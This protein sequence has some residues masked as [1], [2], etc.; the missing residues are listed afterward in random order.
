M[1]GDRNTKFFH[2][3]ANFRRK[4][5][6]IQ[7]ICVDGVCV[8]DVSLMKGAIVNFYSELCREDLPGRPFFKGLSYDTILDGDASDLLKEFSE[9]EVWKAIINLGK[10]KAPGPDGF[11]I[12]FFQHCWSTVKGEIMG[13]FSEFHS[14]GVFEKSLNATF[15]SLIP[16]VAGTN[17][18][19]KFRPIGLVGSVCKILAKVLAPRLRVVVDKL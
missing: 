15:I 9:E 12:T 10:E 13:L 6:A 19:N 4:F 7:S 17:D 11:N 8:D 2:R 5:N 14:K 18:I 1:E 3:L 16:K